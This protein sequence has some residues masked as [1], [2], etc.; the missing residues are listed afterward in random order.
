MKLSLIV[1]GFAIA[2]GG[3]LA[4]MVAYYAWAYNSPMW[5]DIGEILERVDA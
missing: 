1:A 3:V 2:Y 4:A 5:R